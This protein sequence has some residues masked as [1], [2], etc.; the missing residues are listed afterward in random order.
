MSWLAPC[1]D[2]GYR[3]PGGALAAVSLWAFDTFATEEMGVLRPGK[4]RER[5]GSQLLSRTRTAG[6]RTDRPLMGKLGT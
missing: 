1:R 3:G 4:L 2:C 5:K 6:D